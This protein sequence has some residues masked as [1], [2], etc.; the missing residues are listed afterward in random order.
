MARAAT[1]GRS[2]AGDRATAAGAVLFRECAGLGL[3]GLAGF[4]ALALGTYDALDTPFSGDPL[5]N[6][7]GLL[8]AATAG[9]LLRSVGYGSI[10]LVGAAAALGLRM[11]AGHGLPRVASRFWV[12]ATLLVLGTASIPPLLSTSSAGA[13]P[14]L[15]WLGSSL[16][17]QERW[18]LGPAGALLFNGVL[19]A[20]GTLISTGLSTGRAVAAVGV[21]LGWLLAG[22]VKGFLAL[23]AGLGELLARARGALVDLLQGIERGW[24]SLAVWREQ[25]ARHARV[26]RA[27]QGHEDEIEAEDPIALTAL[28]G[29]GDAPPILRA[30]TRKGGPE[31][32]DHS[33]VRNSKKES[34]EA[35]RFEEKRH[36]GPYQLP[37]ISLFQA[38]PQA[39]RSYNRESLIMNSRI[40]EKKLADFGVTGKVVLRHR[41]HR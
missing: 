31:I 35:F 3:V 8:G 39:G 32:V 20:V 38:A 25:R 34:Q 15:G 30:Q 22:V 27:R 28:T 2:R 21:A 24:A 10:L 33:S 16:A 37:D 4:A 12:G 18:L 29:P 26:E 13:G 23:G 41:T 1:K 40:L 5:S 36:A 14:E 11:L 7:G 19:L 6:A 9:A 17:E